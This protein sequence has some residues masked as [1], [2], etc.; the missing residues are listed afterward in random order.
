MGVEIRPQLGRVKD[1]MLTDCGTALEVVHV[2]SAL[3]VVHVQSAL[4]V[5]HVQ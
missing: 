2:Q 5:V 1:S 4:E 3:E